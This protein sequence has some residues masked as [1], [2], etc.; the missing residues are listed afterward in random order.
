M[1]GPSEAKVWFPTGGHGMAF[2]KGNAE[3]QGKWSDVRT[4]A[5]A[6]CIRSASMGLV[7]AQEIIDSVPAGAEP[8]AFTIVAHSLGNNTA[9]NASYKLYRKVREGKL[10]MELVPDRI[11]LVDPYY[12]TLTTGTDSATNNTPGLGAAA[13]A[14]SYDCRYISGVTDSLYLDVL[15]HYAHIP[16]QWYRTSALT[17]PQTNGENDPN[18]RM[19]GRVKF[20]KMYFD[21]GYWTDSSWNRSLDGGYTRLRNKKLKCTF[22]N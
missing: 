1:S 11:D 14:A 6:D 20:Q 7:L 10:G 2:F 3:R 13:F 4:N 16:A 5:A 8:T 19:F 17:Q 22:R 9:I 18:Y 12:G 15:H 21:T